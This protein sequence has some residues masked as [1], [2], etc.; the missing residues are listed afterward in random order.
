MI[1]MRESGGKIHRRQRRDRPV[2]VAK[3]RPPVSLSASGRKGWGIYTAEF[4]LKVRLACWEGMTQR[5]AAKHFNISRDSV[6]RM[7]AYSVQRE[8]ERLARSLGNRQDACC[9]RPWI[10]CMPKG[11]S[12]GFMTAVALSAG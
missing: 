1:R 6:R 5:Q 10:G 7:V 9:T 12:V 4:Y 11:L 8:D 2:A 3:R